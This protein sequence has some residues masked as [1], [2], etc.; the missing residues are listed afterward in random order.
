[1]SAIMDHIQEAVSRTEIRFPTG[2]WCSLSWIR[3]YF[4]TEFRF[5]TLRVLLVQVLGVRL[6][7]VCGALY[8]S[9]RDYCKLY[10]LEAMKVLPVQ[11]P[12]LPLFPTCL[13]FSM[14]DTRAPLSST[15]HPT[16]MMSS[17]DRRLQRCPSD[18]TMR[19]API[20]P[21]LNALTAGMRFVMLCGFPMLFETSFLI[22]TPVNTVLNGSAIKKTKNKNKHTCIL[23]MLTSIR[24]QSSLK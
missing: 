19:T 1:M 16:H 7:A 14:A 17:M 6:Q 5:P 3:F 23:T 20:G 22:T 13:L 18:W 10:G 12:D 21:N 24:R 4:R 2:T 9:A 8:K 11:E 15:P